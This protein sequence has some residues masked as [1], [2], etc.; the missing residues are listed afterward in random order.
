M[1]LEQA[2]KVLNQLHSS[3]GGNSAPAA[4][5]SVALAERSDAMGDAQQE[6]AQDLDTDLSNWLEYM[7]TTQIKMGKYRQKQGVVGYADGLGEGD[8]T[9]VSSVPERENIRKIL[10]CMSNWLVVCGN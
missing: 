6:L 9:F 5:T 2:N 7:L 4:S 3:S 10:V 1:A 8:G